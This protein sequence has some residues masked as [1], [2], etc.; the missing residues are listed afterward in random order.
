MAK[1]KRKY[2]ILM[3]LAAGT[4]IAS[5]VFL[6]LSAGRAAA[7]A[8]P[9]TLIIEGIIIALLEVANNALKMAAA[10]VS[11]EILTTV[12]SGFYYQGLIFEQQENQRTLEALLYD[13]DHEPLP[14]SM[15][16]YEDMN[17]D[18]LYGSLSGTGALSFGSAWSTSG[19]ASASPGYRYSSGSPVVIYSDAHREMIEKTD[20]Y[21]NGMMR[22]NHSEAVGL[23]A[24]A[25]KIKDLEESVMKAGEL[26]EGGYRQILQ[27]ENQVWNH[28]N[29]QAN[30]LRT[31]M[32]RHVDSA[33]RFS[34]DEI[35]R[36]TDA[37]SAFEQAV[38]IWNGPASASG[39]Y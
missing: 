27:A 38:M 20:A 28:S 16:V 31:D 3:K 2:G 4:L 33:V 1:S 13:L 37:A 14:D 15:K 9:V 5:M 30:R 26:T 21:A 22:A 17:L 39:G 24:T 6:P 36:R 19:F 12:D 7:A 18:A 29:V 35:Q 10:N 8:D 11:R 32:A 34:L 23:S 25:Q